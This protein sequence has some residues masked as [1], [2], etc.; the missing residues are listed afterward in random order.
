[1]IEKLAV[2]SPWAMR[3][4][5]GILAYM[6]GRADVE[7]AGRANGMETLSE[8]AKARVRAATSSLASHPIT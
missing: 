5:N 7:P 1:M 8:S 4:T 2:R 3:R 6:E